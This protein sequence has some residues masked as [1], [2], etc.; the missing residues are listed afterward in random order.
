[1]PKKMKKYEKKRIKEVYK[2][3][4]K[5]EMNRTLEMTSFLKQVFIII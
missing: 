3:V 4:K 2:D 1:M 5:M